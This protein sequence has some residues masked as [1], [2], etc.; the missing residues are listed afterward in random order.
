MGAGGGKGVPGQR[1]QHAWR[2][3]GR[4]A[5]ALRQP[6]RL[7]IRKG[8]ALALGLIIGCFPSP[9]ASLSKGGHHRHLPT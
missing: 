6:G 2:P 9:G 5:G 3:R 7:F 1:E 4:R 8:Q